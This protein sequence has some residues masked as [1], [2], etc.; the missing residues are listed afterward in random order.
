MKLLKAL[1]PG[2]DRAVGKLARNR[3]RQLTGVRA[4]QRVVGEDALVGERLAGNGDAHGACDRSRRHRLEDGMRLVRSV[5]ED[6]VQ[7]DREI[8]EQEQTLECRL[9]DTGDVLGSARGG[10]LQVRDVIPDVLRGTA[11][12]VDRQGRPRKSGFLGDGYC[13][14]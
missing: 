10:E 5:V 14:P 12:V 6:A 2:G 11:A 8:G 9:V 7:G 1:R 4:S 13:P 3:P